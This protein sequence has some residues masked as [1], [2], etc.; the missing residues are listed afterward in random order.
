MA[1]Y[2]ASVAETAN[3]GGWGAVAWGS[4]VF[5]STPSVTDSQYPSGTSSVTVNE[6]F[7]STW[8]GNTW[9][10]GVWGGQSSLVDVVTDFVSDNS[11]V[12]E[13]ATATDS[14]SSILSTANT[15]S[16]SIT[17]T[18]T[19]ATSYVTSATVTEISTVT[20]TVDA[21]NTITLQIIEGF[22][23]GWG[24]LGWGQSVWGGASTLVDI[25]TD[26]VAFNPA[27][28]ETITVTDVVSSQPIYSLV[29]S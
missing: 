18:D 22:A 10:F 5:G 2:N 13:T 26:Y 3:N 28:N 23:V 1:V 25:V 11:T 29:V 14:L 4:D 12:S 15:V 27:V 17:V 9:G 16:E 19:I 7:L 21:G 6:G 24:F 20:D 8:G